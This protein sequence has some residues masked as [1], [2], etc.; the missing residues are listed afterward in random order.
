MV[1][2]PN[3]MM[4][5]MQ[6]NVHSGKGGTPRTYTVEKEGQQGISYVKALVGQLTVGTSDGL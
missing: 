4:M 1:L 2:Y 6:Q 5:Q 3:L